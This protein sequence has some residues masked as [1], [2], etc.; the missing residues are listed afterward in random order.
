MCDKICNSCGEPQC[1]VMCICKQ[2]E[3][4]ATLC[5]ETIDYKCV[6]LEKKDNG[7]PIVFPCLDIESG[8]SLL[9]LTGKL[10]TIVCGLGD[11]DFFDEKVKTNGS[12]STAGFLADKI[13]GNTC[14]TWTTENIAGNIK[15]KPVLDFQCIWNQI[16]LLGDFCATVEACE[17]CVPPSNVTLFFDEV[18]NVCPS[19]IVNLTALVDVIPANVTVEWHSNITHT[20]IIPT[21][22]AYNTTNGSP[23]YVFTRDN[24]TG[25]YSSALAVVV[26]DISCNALPAVSMNCAGSVSIQS[27]VFKKGLGST[28]VINLPITVGAGTGNISVVVSGA[29]FTNN[30]VFNQ[31]VTVLTTSLNIPVT[32]DGTGSIGNHLVTFTINGALASP[33]TCLFNIPVVCPPCILISNDIVI[34][35]VDSSGFTVNIDGLVNTPVCVDTYDISIKDNS[36]DLVVVSATNQTSPT[37]VF[38]GGNPSFEYSIMV[39]K[40]CCCGNSSSEVTVTQTLDECIATTILANPVFPSA[41]ANVPYNFNFQLAGTQPFTQRPT[42]NRRPSWMTEIIVGDIVT[43]GGTPPLILAGTKFSVNLAYDN[44]NEVNPAMLIQTQISII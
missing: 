11:Q 27:G 31:A 3:Y 18:Q 17:T 24:D 22:S 32:Y 10:E 7:D 42:I 30:G 35:D 9:K 29:G 19:K 40:K 8:D 23:V 44:C 26:V 13:I 14:I 34:T 37:Y 41:F 25:C 2:A 5:E 36:N 15:L 4:K 20:A 28:G 1:E 6:Q 43:F 16:K 21:P 38:T 12:D 39:T 33:I